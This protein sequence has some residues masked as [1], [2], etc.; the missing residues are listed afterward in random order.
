MLEFLSVEPAVK[1]GLGTAILVTIAGVIMIFAGKFVLKLASSVGLG[2][3]MG[4]LGYKYVAVN[5]NLGD[6]AGLVAFLILFAFFVIFGWSL[7]KLAISLLAAV[8]IWLLA[9]NFIGPMFSPTSLIALFVI[10]L[11]LFF[12]S[13]HLLTV[14]AIAAGALLVYVGIYMLTNS[15]LVALIIPFVLILLRSPIFQRKKR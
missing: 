8:P 7:F 2:L 6:M 4:Y 9:L 12:L 1:L 3:L 13:E 15:A 5:L 10:L 14:I 11:V